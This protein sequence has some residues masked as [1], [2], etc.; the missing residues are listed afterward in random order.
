MSERRWGGAGENPLAL[1]HLGLPAER[2]GEVARVARGKTEAEEAETPDAP[3]A[4]GAG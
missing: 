1:G 2:A 4:G 3:E